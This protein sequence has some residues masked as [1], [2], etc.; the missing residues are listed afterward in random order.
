MG[1]IWL[2]G[3]RFADFEL[4]LIFL[5]LSKVVSLWPGSCPFRYLLE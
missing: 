4:E 3:P 2:V 1:Q 5:I